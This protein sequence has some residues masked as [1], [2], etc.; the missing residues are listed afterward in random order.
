MGWFRPFHVKALSAREQRARLAARETLVRQV[1]DLENSI[2]SLL[3]GFGLHVPVRLGGRCSATV[4]S[5][6]EDHPSLAITLEPL[7]RAREML[8]EQLAIID[9]HPGSCGGRAQTM[10]RSKIRRSTNPLTLTPNDRRC[11]DG[12]FGRLPNC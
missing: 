8:R 1:R 4:R 7:L 3:R 2:R 12:Q 10:D 9:R 6:V 11:P 5:L